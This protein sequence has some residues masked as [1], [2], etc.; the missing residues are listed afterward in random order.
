MI[1]EQVLFSREECEFILNSAKDYY[2][3]KIISQESKSSIS[4][5]RTSYESTIDIDGQLKKLLI[6][7][8]KTFGVKSLPKNMKII[9]YREGTEFKKHKDAAKIIADR[10]KSISIQLN[11]TYDNGELK[12]WDV[13]DKEFIAS[14]E[15][16]N[17][18]IF[19]SDLYHQ[20]LPPSIGVRYS[21]VL[22]LSLENM[23]KS[24]G[25]I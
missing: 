12:I 23:G 4:N 3:S 18:V 1:Q 2:R 15:L 7:K 21:A 17:A 9:R 22:W 5:R 10:Y 19:D 25:L 14:K 16:G 11:D 24:R 6:D 13:D 8:F 20:A